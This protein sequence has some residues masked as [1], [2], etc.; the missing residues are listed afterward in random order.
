MSLAGVGRKVKQLK[1]L[2]WLASSAEASERLVGSPVFK[3]GAGPFT[4]PEGSIPY[5]SANRERV[6]YRFVTYPV[7]NLSPVVA[8]LT[9][10]PPGSRES[11]A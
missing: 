1:G 10:L 7:T 5:A 8:C 9:P 6:P 3:T 2:R 11:A 4:G